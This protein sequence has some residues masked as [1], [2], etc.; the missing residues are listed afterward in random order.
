M[1]TLRI[2][3]A[4]LLGLMLMLAPS[5]VAQA[6]GTTNVT[7]HKLSLASLTGWP[8]GTDGQGSTGLN[9]SKYTG[10]QITDIQGFFGDGTTG[11][12]GVT[13]TYWKVTQAQ[14]EAMKSAPAS[15]DT[16]AEVTAFESGPFTTTTVE[17]GATPTLALAD[18]YY[19]FVESGKPE[20]VTGSAAVPFG[21]VLPMN[22]A[23]GSVLSD[24]HVYPKNTVKDMPTVD[25]DVTTDGN[26]SDSANVGDSVTWIIQ[27][28]L[29]E[30]VQQYTKLTFTDPIDPALDFV[31][32]S[33]KV[34]NGTGGAAL[35][36]GTDY[37]V[38][39]NSTTRDLV[40]DFTAD[41]IKKLVNGMTITFDTII[42][43]NAV[44]GLPIDN[45]VKLD[46]TNS[47]NVTGWTD[48]TPTEQPEVWTGGKKFEKVIEGTTTGLAG[49]VFKLDGVNW[50]TALL[51]ANDAAIKAGQFATCTGTPLA[52]T[53]T[54]ANNMPSADTQVYLMSNSSGYFEIAG[55]QG[56]EPTNTTDCTTADK[57]NTVTHTG[58]YTLTEVVAPAGYGML[59]TPISFQ[60]TKTSYWADPAATTLVAAA[61]QLV[62]NKKV[63][64]PETGG[65]GT[66]VFTVAGLALM[67]GAVFGMRRRTAA[68]KA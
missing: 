22:Q 30:F 64:I 18:G 20:A 32:S 52:C 50:T 55:L 23:D 58:Q 53:P 48:V 34:T 29:T 14:Y 16:V 9:D 10:G 5:T 36:V 43:A 37:T 33:V 24:V 8:R 11:L 56:Y 46:Y 17:G 57:C 66:I 59:T 54:S 63:T 28:T 15:Y 1:R 40:I 12:K 19:W 25:K 44:I 26:D 7:I 62:A 47:N 39:Y 49:A 21:L 27:P 6:A 38:N 13:F 41:G 51:A 31:A 60:V 65:I 68:A 61:P 35:V 2:I 67:G 3:G 42:N 4:F 45:N